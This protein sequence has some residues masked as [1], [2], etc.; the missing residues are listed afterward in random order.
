MSTP[1]SMIA[2]PGDLVSPVDGSDWCSVHEGPWMATEGDG[3][4][5][6]LRQRELLDELTGRLWPML[7]PPRL[8]SL[9]LTG[10]PLR[11]LE[12]HGRGRSLWSS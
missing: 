4:R 12:V 3:L 1:A 7:A 9:D 6:L 8:D 10:G 2:R 11:D 5:A